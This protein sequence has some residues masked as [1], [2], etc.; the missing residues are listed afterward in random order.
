MTEELGMYAMHDTL[1]P[2]TLKVGAYTLCHQ[3]EGKIW[4]QHESGEGAEFAESALADVIKKFY[5]ENF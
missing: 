1:K 3:S 5:D 4:M 2:G